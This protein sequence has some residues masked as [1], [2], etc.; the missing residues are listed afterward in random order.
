[1]PMPHKDAVRTMAVLAG[2]E[3]YHISGGEMAGHRWPS[4]YSLCEM[5][6][7]TLPIIHVQQI[8]TKEEAERVGLVCPV[9]LRLYHQGQQEATQ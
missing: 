2:A 7:Q 4:Y 8:K 1:M 9:C 5:D 3:P 6:D